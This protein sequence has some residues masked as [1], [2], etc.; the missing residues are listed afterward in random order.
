MSKKIAMILTVFAASC[1][2]VSAQELVPTSG[3][4]FEEGDF[5]PVS[6]NEEITTVKTVTGAGVTNG[7]QAVLFTIDKGLLPK[8]EYNNDTSTKLVFEAPAEGWQIKDVF[9]VDLYN[10]GSKPIQIRA[11]ITDAAG[12]TAMYYTS[13]PGKASHT[14]KL[15]QDL[16]VKQP[17]TWAVETPVGLANKSLDVSNI[18]SIGFGI[19]ELAASPGDGFV[20]DN[21]YGI[22][23][24]GTTTYELPKKEVNYGV[25]VDNNP[26]NEILI[27]NPQYL[28]LTDP[29]NIRQW[30]MSEMFSDEFDGT[31][32][33]TTKW[34][35]YHRFWTG[36]QPSIFDPKNVSVGDGLLVLTSTWEDE[37]TDLMIEANKKLK[38]G[39]AIYEDISASAVQSIEPTGY[40]YYELRAKTAP[41][42]IASAFWFRDPKVSKQEIDI[43]E[44]VGRPVNANRLNL[45]GSS[46]PMNTHWFKEGTDISNGRIYNTGVDLTADFHIYGFEWDTYYL[47]FYIDGV[48]VHEI[49][50]SIDYKIDGSQYLLFD[51]ETNI[52][53]SKPPEKEAF[54]YK[55]GE[56]NPADYEIDYIRVWRSDIPQASN[57]GVPASRDNLDL[58][59]AKVKAGIE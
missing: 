33:D 44:Q 37:P 15:T 4:T 12:T 9:S 38:P 49:D 11:F 53:G 50:N 13:V 52:Y 59:T 30:K 31:E 17:E 14:L 16:F 36:R 5:I 24:A 58:N 45:N 34:S 47:R 3:F 22:S 1:G 43:F 46:Y 54:E 19:Y 39:D 10:P 28:P 48:L 55:P 42:S 51:M 18:K 2:V 25:R 56:R 32:L 41:I 8:G 7:D 20:I 6:S 57:P 26:A 35:G 21:M 29:N 27:E 23:G 40:G